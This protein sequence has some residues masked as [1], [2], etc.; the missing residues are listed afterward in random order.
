MIN[1]YLPQMKRGTQKYTELELIE[2]IVWNTIPEAWQ[3][4]FEMFDGPRA[5]TMQQVQTI[6]Q[7]V[8][9]CENLEKR[10]EK[11]KE[12]TQKKSKS[13]DNKSD[14]GSKYKNPCRKPGHDHE[15]DNCPDNWKNKKKSGDSQEKFN[16]E[17]KS[18]PG[19]F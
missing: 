10:N 19:F 11:T 8:E 9:R 13:N 12:N 15:W 7:K 3:R 16:I 4:D 14:K 6:L 5:T 17:Q 1:N 18:E 2:K